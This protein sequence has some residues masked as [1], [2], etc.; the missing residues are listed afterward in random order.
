MMRRILTVV[1]AAL[2]TAVPTFAQ[3]SNGS[4]YIVT[5][6]DDAVAM[7]PSTTSL[8][9]E[10]A[11]TYGGSVESANGSSIVVKML[12]PRV[13]MLRSDPRVRHVGE[14]PRTLKRAPLGSGSMSWSLSYDGAGNISAMGNDTYRYDSAGRLLT[15]TVDNASNSMSYAYDSFGNRTSATAGT[16]ATR[17]VG[18]TDCDKTITVNPVTNR[19]TGSGA[20]CHDD[21]GNTVGF[22][23]CYD[24]A[25]NLTVLDVGTTFTYDAASMVTSDTATNSQSIY[26][27]DDER[28][29]TYA[30]ST[31]TWTLRDLDNQP[32]RE[33]TSTDTATTWGTANL[34]WTR[35]YVWRG[36]ALL[37]SEARGS[38]A[39]TVTEHFHLD[40][41]GTPRLVTNGTGSKIGY[42][43]YYPFGGELDLT[44]V[45]TPESKLK[46]TSHA[47][48]TGRGGGISLDY[49]HARSF[50]ATLG[51]FLSV[52][53]HVAKFSAPQS[54]NRYSYSQN[55]PLMRIDSDGQHDKIFFVNMLLN[56]QPGAREDPVNFD[57]VKSEIERGTQYT[58][59]VVKAE[60]GTTD[61]VL[62]AV[63]KMDPDG[64]DVLIA[65]GHGGYDTDHGG[66]IG[67]SGVANIDTPSPHLDYFIA[68]GI[69]GNDFLSRLST[70][71]TNPAGTALFMGCGTDQFARTV[72]SNTNMTAVGTNGEMAIKDEARAAAV[73]ASVYARTG[74]IRSARIA[75]NHVIQT[76]V[77]RKRI[78]IS[79]P[80]A[81]E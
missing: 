29:A 73:F 15:A 17:C 5:V 63:W 62:R 79:P 32:L 51:R 2:L 28:I 6:S 25:G 16:S 42:H 78:Q 49:M 64:T 44:S 3:E 39:T 7:A 80:N 60:G 48:D 65:I 43:S 31:W 46:F 23:V 67:Y 55:N 81:N 21:L 13:A 22:G 18:N 35:D 9:Q 50:S 72:S 38:G 69:N 53:R 57:A 52:D 77:K 70:T 61:D 4:R 56:S 30:T 66:L 74:D 27:A 20:A 19:L 11:E 12:P 37:A 26:T 58:V 59:E 8:A 36:N 1:I 75:A 45:E 14:A 41:L 71:M 47:R 33:F 54:W 24:A 34:T 76:I 40:H 68:G 10:I